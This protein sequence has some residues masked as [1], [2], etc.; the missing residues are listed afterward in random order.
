[1]LKR[2]NASEIRNKQ[3]SLKIPIVRLLYGVTNSL[4]EAREVRIDLEQN[5]AVV[6]IDSVFGLLLLGAL[7]TNFIREGISWNTLTFGTTVAD[8]IR[9]MLIDITSA[10]DFDDNRLKI[11]GKIEELKN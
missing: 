1:M 11:R 5:R 10:S 2:T 6:L 8:S 4:S 9:Y 3:F 7:M